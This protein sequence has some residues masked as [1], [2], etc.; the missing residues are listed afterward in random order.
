MLRHMEKGR[1]ENVSG[2]AVGALVEIETPEYKKATR[3]FTQRP[4]RET[5]TLYLYPKEASMR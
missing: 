2:S 4:T 5:S 3:S 1:A